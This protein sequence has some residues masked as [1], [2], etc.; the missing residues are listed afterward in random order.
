MVAAGVCVGQVFSTQREKDTASWEI[1]RLWELADDLPIEEVPVSSLEHF[2]DEVVWFLTG[3]DACGDKPTARSVAEHS[4]RIYSADLSYPI[5]LS[6][7]GEVMDGMH[8][9]AKAWMMG[10]ETI[11]V[12][13]F[14]VDP[15]PDWVEVWEDERP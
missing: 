5:I 1:E 10:I 14:T 6:A 11:K 15:D 4:E 12:R 3:P 2:L 8:R 9:L 7:V 13:R